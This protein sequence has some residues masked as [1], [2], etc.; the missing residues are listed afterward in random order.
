[1][2][3]A[4]VELTRDYEPEQKDRKSLIWT[5]R[6]RTMALLHA[7]FHSLSFL[8]YTTVIYLLQFALF[9]P[10]DIFDLPPDLSLGLLALINFFVF[11]FIWWTYRSKISEDHS[12]KSDDSD[13][14]ERRDMKLFVNIVRALS[15]RLNIGDLARGVAVA[16]SVAANIN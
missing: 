6:M 15:H 5:S 2:D 16:G 10:I 9:L 7:M 13:V 8:I 3:V 4:V 14:V 1:M 11:G 12:E